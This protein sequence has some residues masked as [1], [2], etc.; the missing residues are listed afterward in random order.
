MIDPRDLVSSR[1]RLSTIALGRCCARYHEG[2]CWNRMALSTS[3]VYKPRPLPSYTTRDW[4]PGWVRRCAISSWT[5]TRT[6]TSPS[7]GSCF[8]LP[9]LSS[10]HLRGRRRGPA[11]L[12]FS[13]RQPPG[14]RRLSTALSRCSGSWSSPPITA[15]TVTSWRPATV[16]FPPSTGPIMRERP[17]DIPRPSCPR[18]PQSQRRPSRGS[19][20]IIGK[21]N[22]DVANQ[23]PT[24]LLLL[25]GQGSIADMGQ[26]AILLPSVSNGATGATTWTP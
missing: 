8:A 14:I 23:L 16:G 5:S 24:L 10:Q 17:S 9:K 3:P 21:H 20:G 12:S 7:S 6:P 13:R 26:V 11:H 15:A 22:A 4:P 2:V 25:R 1:A 19:L 18:V